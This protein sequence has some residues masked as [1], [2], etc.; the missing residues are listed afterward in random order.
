[1]QS[2]HFPRVLKNYAIL[3]DIFRKIVNILRK[4]LVIFKMISLTISR[5]LSS[6]LG[7]LFLLKEKI[8]LCISED[9]NR[10]SSFIEME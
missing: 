10:I 8:P 5:S 2:L 4:L 9:V 6:E 7:V 1:M 3:G